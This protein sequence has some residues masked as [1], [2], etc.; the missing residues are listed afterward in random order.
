MLGVFLCL[1]KERKQEEVLQKQ[2]VKSGAQEK[3]I[4]RLAHGVSFLLFWQ[5]E[6]AKSSKILNYAVNF[7]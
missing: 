2:F 7:W 1:Q 3:S 5:N 4:S 6:M